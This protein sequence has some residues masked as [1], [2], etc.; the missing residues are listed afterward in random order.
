MVSVN[1]ITFVVLKL[2]HN[3]VFMQNLC[4]QTTADL[5]KIMKN[6]KPDLTFF[7]TEPDLYFHLFLMSLVVEI[8]N[9]VN[10]RK[11]CFFEN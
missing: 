3:L 10:L 4:L 11:T 6:V 5:S 1:V 8:K 7:F 2:L 9:V